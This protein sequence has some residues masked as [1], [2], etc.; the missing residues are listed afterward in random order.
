MLSCE[1]YFGARVV[2]QDFQT[3][4]M[5]QVHSPHS[6]AH[7]S[8]IWLPSGGPRAIG[9][10]RLSVP[11][12]LSE[13]DRPLGLLALI[14]QGKKWSTA[15]V[16]SKLHDSGFQAPVRVAGH[17]AVCWPRDY[18]RPEA[19]RGAAKLTYTVISESL[20]SPR[21]P[22]FLFCFLFLSRRSRCRLSLVGALSLDV[23]RSNQI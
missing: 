19:V 2:R 23:R 14:V 15:G 20:V 8:A 13:L 7:R 9:G 17:V 6:P 18:A 11:K 12:R 21:K 22:F 4:E 5:E 10:T 16:P 3:H 1:D